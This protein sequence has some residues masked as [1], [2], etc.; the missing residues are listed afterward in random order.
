MKGISGAGT[1]GAKAERSE[2]SKSV[3]RRD[4][5]EIILPHWLPY[6]EKTYIYQNHKVRSDFVLMMGK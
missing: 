2:S 6:L 4:E 1:G 5:R 3:P